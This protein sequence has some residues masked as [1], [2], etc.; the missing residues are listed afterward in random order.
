MARRGASEKNR[1]ETS[2]GLR[3]EQCAVVLG[4]CAVSAEGGVM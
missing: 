4:Q 1:K 3:H 2:L